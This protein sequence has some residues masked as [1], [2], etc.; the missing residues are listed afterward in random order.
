MLKLIQA[1]L[2]CVMTI[3]WITNI[4]ASLINDDFENGDM[5]GRLFELGM[6]VPAIVKEFTDRSGQVYTPA[7]GEYF[8][9]IPTGAGLIWTNVQWQK[10]DR[11][12]F[13]YLLADAAEGSFQLHPEWPHTG[14]MIARL[15]DDVGSW[16]T[17]S[18]EF[19]GAEDGAIAL[20]N[21]GDFGSFLLVDNV[22]IIKVVAPSSL[23]L[24]L[25]GL[26]G[27]LARKRFASDMENK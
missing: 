7:S 9:T 25:M 21:F 22:S 19:T 15:V 2:V 11:V 17:F 5:G 6:G 12:E 27:L 14:D 24:G 4:Q 20:Q 10:G 13:Q 16:Q 18:Y 1:L 26:F 23:L 3:G 8:A